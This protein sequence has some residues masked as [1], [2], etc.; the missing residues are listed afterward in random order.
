MKDMIPI[1]MDMGMNIMSPFEAAAGSDIVEMARE[2]PDLVMTGGIDKRVIAAGKEEID[3][4]LERVLGPM[5]SRGGYI[6][7]CDHGVPED[8]S[9]ENYLYYR[10]RAVELGS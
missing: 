8:V 9:Y 2:F 3:R 4:Y 10:K 1:Y 5:R 6:P 7:T